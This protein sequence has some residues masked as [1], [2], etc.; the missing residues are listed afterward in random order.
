MSA[1]DALTEIKRLD[2]EIDRVDRLRDR[3]AH[4]PDRWEALTTVIDALVQQRIAMT[5]DVAS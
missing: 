1:M 3:Q 4:I 2:T 5:H